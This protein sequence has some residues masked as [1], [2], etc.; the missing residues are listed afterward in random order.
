MARR[1]LVVGSLAA[2][3]GL[4]MVVSPVAT[5]N[6]PSRPPTTESRVAL[7]AQAVGGGWR[8]DADVHADLVGVKWSGDPH[9]Q[10]T[11]S[12]RDTLGRWSA[13]APLDTVDTGP[14]PGTAEAAHAVTNATEPVWVRGSTGVRVQLASGG[15]T[16]VDLHTVDAPNPTHPSSSADAAVAYPG[17]ISRAQWGADESLRYRNCNGAPQYS[18]RLRF[19]VV[20]H[21]ADGNTYSPADSFSIVRGIYTYS[22]V[23]L[24]YCDMMYNFL[25][26]KY[27][28]I[29]E[30]RYGGVDKP[31]LGAH[32]IG[33]NTESVGIAM[34]GNYMT[35]QP[36][37]VAVDA[38]ERLIA[39]KFWVDHVDPRAPVAYTTSGN[40][41]F[42]AGTTV[43]IPTIVGH[44]DTWFT[45]CPGDDL[46]ALLPAI[47]ASVASRVSD[48]PPVF[49][50]WVP[51]SGAARLLA[52]D[53]WGG[54][55]P[56]GGQAAVTPT[57]YWPGWGMARGAAELPGGAGGYVLDGYGAL[58]PY[59]AAPPLRTTGYW[60]GWDIARD[61]ALLPGGAGGYVLDGFGG[62]H[63]FG[64]APA[65]A[66]SGY[67]PG[68]D[69]ARRLVVLPSGTGGYVL[70][71]WGSLHRFGT[72]PALATHGYWPGWDIARD[73]AVRPGTSFVYVLD[74]F[75]GIWPA[76]G[77]PAVPA[78]YFGRDAARGLVLT[79]AGGGYALRDDGG[80]AA[81]G[82]APAV[83][84]A[85]SVLSPPNAVA[86]TTG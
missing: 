48:S 22:V 54:L 29:F 45:A 61:V 66:V 50:S 31:V 35:T 81:F 16:H 56:A 73:V 49:P 1:W 27:G 43:T 15:A 5:T 10:F 23:T 55:Y 17:I 38:L 18:D 57:G 84:Q 79:S 36:S 76:T 24:G 74:G 83:L 26:D 28:Q 6:G 52:L 44:R 25:V 70:D 3:L 2:V 75:G 30:G 41:K 13:P 19:A 8:A 65:V 62:L 85:Q 71:G 60:P 69:I 33:F 58:H 64:S 46:Y 21:T 78:P 32:A 77:A 53:A 39:W 40:D 12:T 42:A 11:V 9:A 68:W 7:A 51:Q 34:I 67:W 80:I 72:A 63:P 37:A 20:H 14:D 47:R 4:V 59:G 82:G 86:L